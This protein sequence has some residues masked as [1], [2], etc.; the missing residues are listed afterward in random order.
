MSLS[1]TMRYWLLFN[2]M[3]L[4][5]TLDTMNMHKYKQWMDLNNKY[6]IMTKKNGNNNIV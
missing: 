1:K 5:N 4:R 6:D 2:D 3:I